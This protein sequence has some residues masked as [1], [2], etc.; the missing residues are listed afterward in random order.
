MDDCEFDF[1]WF[2]LGL[3]LKWSDLFLESFYLNSNFVVEL[4][5]KFSTDAKVVFFT[6]C[7]M[8]FNKYMHAFSCGVEF[9]EVECTFDQFKCCKLAN[10][11]EIWSSMSSCSRPILQAVLW[12]NQECGTNFLWNLDNPQTLFLLTNIFPLSLLQRIGSRIG[13]V[14][15]MVLIG[16]CHTWILLIDEPF[17]ICLLCASIK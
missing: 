16:I 10:Y 3:C 13:S 2:W 5:I 1:R 17:L 12:S 15:S 7:Q 8:C 9:A 11:V 4:N 14:L 6:F